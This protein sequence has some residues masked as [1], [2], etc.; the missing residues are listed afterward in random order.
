[1]DYFPNNKILTRNHA[2]TILEYQWHLEEVI[3]TVKWPIVSI[4]FRRTR[5]S[6][7]PKERFTNVRTKGK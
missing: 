6:M 1:M 7:F 2:E 4:Q 3:N 5:A